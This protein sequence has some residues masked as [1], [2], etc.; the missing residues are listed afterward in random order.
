MNPEKIVTMIGLVLMLSLKALTQTVSTQSVSGVLYAENFTYYK[1][2]GEGWLRLE[3]HSLV[4]DADLYISG[5]TS[6]PTYEDYE[7]KSDS[8][9]VDIIDIHSSIQR[10]VGIGIYAHP[11][12]LKTSFKLDIAVMNENELDEYEQLFQQFHHFDFDEEERKASGKSARKSKMPLDA[13]EKEE[14]S[15]WWTILITIL[16]FILEILTEAA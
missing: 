16:K 4:G 13:S 8:C 3:L 5:L 9:G 2:N 12:Y 6:Q 1:L 7:L 15:I 10:P 11:L 14:E